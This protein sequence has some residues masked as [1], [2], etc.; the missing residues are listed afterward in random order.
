MFKISSVIAQ[1]IFI[2]A[3]RFLQYTEATVLY[4]INR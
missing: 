3:G 2:G 1:S 4:T